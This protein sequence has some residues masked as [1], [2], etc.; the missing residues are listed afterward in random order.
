MISMKTSDEVFLENSMAFNRRSG[1]LLERT[2]FN[3]RAIVLL[4]CLIATMLLGWQATRLK[5]NAGF[6]KMIPLQ[7]EFVVNYMANKS[8]LAG[9]GN[10]LRIVVSTEQGNIFTAEYMEVLRKINDEVFLLPGVERSHMKSL[11]TPAVRWVAVTED[12]LEGGPVIPDNFDGSPA[13]LEELRTNV[14]RSGQLGQ[15]VAFDYKSTTIYVPLFDR[16][17]EGRQLDYHAFSQQLEAIRTKYEKGVVKVHIIGFAKVVGELIDG[18]REVLMFFGLAIVICTVVLYAHTRC[19]RSTTL[20]VAC[21]LLAVVWLLGLL[22]ALGYELDP[23]S[24]LV[25]FLVFAIGMSHGAQKM[26]G[27]MQDVGRGMDKVVAARYTFRRLFLAGTTAL[28]ADAV[29]FGVLMVIQ[30][31]VIQDLAVA[32]SLGVGILIFTNLVLLPIL[33][34]YVGVSPAAAARSMEANQAD[35]ADASHRKHPMWAFLDL[36]TQRRWATW[37]LAVAVILAVLGYGVGRGLKIGDLEPGAPELRP[38]SRYNQDNSYITAHY[39]ASSDAYVVMVRTQPFQCN[40]YESLAA[41]DA[42]EWELQQLPQVESTRSFSGFAKQASVGMNEG[43]FQWF[44]IPRNQGQL[45]SVANRGAP[46]ELINQNCD[47]VTL[48]AY[49]K[50]HKAESLEGVVK[51]VSDFATR[52]NSDKIKF[53]SAAGSAGIEA[54]TN[55]VVKEADR[56]ILWLVYAAVTI[57]AFVVFRSVRAVAC[58]IIPLVVTTLLAEAL[59]VLLGIGVKV[60]TLPVIALGVGIGVDYALYVLTVTLAELRRGKTLSQA[61][62]SALL[63]TGKV[64]VLTGLTL[65]GAVCIWAASPIKFQADMGLLLAFMFLWNMLGALI[66]LPALAH[67]LLKPAARAKWTSQ[68]VAPSA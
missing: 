17:P 2:I 57:L 23:Y 55:I 13:S 48:Y 3:H 19:W 5:V 14:M 4:L 46:R 51:V 26:N 41:I 66:L 68:A 59:M 29:G 25:P 33:L 6:E 52:H 53:L 58:A 42:L 37:A 10:A 47:L 43:A 16:D 28:L 35:V 40:T 65:S 50:D 63:F 61:Y 62:Y 60:A 8:E 38:S 24:V 36:F 34:S 27:I 11:W 45:N 30:I 39:A 56:R 64:V 9:L 49:L 54:A 31:Q 67:F 1:S 7:H 20:V 18:L 15:L 44:D 21:S 12:G 32:A 22:P